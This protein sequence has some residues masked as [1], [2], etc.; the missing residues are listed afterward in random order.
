MNQI[1]EVYRSNWPSA[2]AAGAYKA[3]AEDKVKYLDEYEEKG[4]LEE[5]NSLYNELCLVNREKDWTEPI[6]FLIHQIGMAYLLIPH[7]HIMIYGDFLYIL[8][9]LAII[10]LMITIIIMGLLK[11]ML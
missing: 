9:V 1:L 10:I 3:I 4:D 7:Q 8:I 2:L 11:N 5:L 6:G